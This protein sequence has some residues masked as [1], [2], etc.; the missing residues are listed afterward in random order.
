MTIGDRTSF[1]VGVS[2]CVRPNEFFPR[3]SSRKE[4]GKRT[5]S[6]RLALGQTPGL[7]TPVWSV[8]CLFE[9]FPRPPGPVGPSPNSP[10]KVGVLCGTWGESSKGHH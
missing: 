7:E 1:A 9:S 8:V 2:T 5:S 3:V 10:S 4:A 6:V